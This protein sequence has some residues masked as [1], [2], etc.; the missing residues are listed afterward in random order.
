MVY[1][2]ASKTFD[3]FMGNDAL[4]QTSPPFFD[5]LNRRGFRI[6]RRAGLTS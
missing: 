6:A 1:G 5:K 4:A 2:R 3:I